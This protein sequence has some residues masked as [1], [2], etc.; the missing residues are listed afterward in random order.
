[1]TI[2]DFS[3]STFSLVFSAAIPPVL[4]VRPGDTVRTFTLDNRGFDA[5]GTP[6]SRPGNPLTGPFYIEGAAR[7][8]TLAITLKSIRLNRDAARS[9]ARLARPA[10]TR[11]YRR[12]AHYGSSR[13][14][15]W[16][17]DRERCTAKL[18]APLEG[19]KHFAVPLRPFLGC[20]GVA[21]ASDQAFGPTWLGE[22]GGN[23]DYNRLIEGTTLHLPV[24]QRG[25]LLSLGDGHAAQ[26]DGELTGDA[27]ETSMDIEFTVDVRSGDPEPA[28]VGPRAENARELM[29]FG[30]ADSMTEAF[31]KSTVALADWVARDYHLSDGETALVLGTSIRYDVAEIVDPKVNIVAR[32]SKATLAMLS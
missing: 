6:R 27:L 2:H 26:G 32:I 8:D 21:P 16:H 29:A 30:I 3:P 13:T 7:G 28:C 4:R 23:L 20:I 12:R 10:V 24:F 17:L 18:A 9:G 11:D 5:H 31:Q 22:W 1:V 14:I 25:G 19:L 15:E